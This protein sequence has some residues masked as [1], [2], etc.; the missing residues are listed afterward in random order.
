MT[1]IF[2]L[3]A[4]F[5]VSVD[6]QYVANT[7][8]VTVSSDVKISEISWQIADIKPFKTIVQSDGMVVYLLFRKTS[9]TQFNLAPHQ[10]SSEFIGPDLVWY[11]STANTGFGEFVTD[12]PSNTLELFG[13]LGVLAVGIVLAATIA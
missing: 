1:A 8:I 13:G 11:I 5:R 6:L 10:I 2:Q 4:S 3:D 9:I 7:G 12:A